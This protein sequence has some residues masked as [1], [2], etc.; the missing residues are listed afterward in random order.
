[1]PS[2]NSGLGCPGPG[3]RFIPAFLSVAHKSSPMVL[4]GLRLL[5]DLMLILDVMILNYDI[6]NDKLDT[7]PDQSEVTGK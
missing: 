3:T 7:Y 2:E 6:T 1:M 4:P 5:G